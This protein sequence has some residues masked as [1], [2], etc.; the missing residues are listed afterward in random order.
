MY[1]C[2]HDGIH[3]YSLTIITT[4]VDAQSEHRA[5]DST[6]WPELNRCIIGMTD[7]LG[8]YVALGWF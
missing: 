6:R 4:I 8:L 2:H 7:T 5:A 1:Y 3:F